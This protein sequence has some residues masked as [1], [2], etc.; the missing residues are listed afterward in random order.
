M[1][2]LPDC[3]AELAEQTARRMLA[4]GPSD[5]SISIGVATWDAQEQGYELMQRADRAMYAAK[6]AGGNTVEPDGAPPRGTLGLAV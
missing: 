5:Q 3:P 4:G 6:A 1:V 2:L